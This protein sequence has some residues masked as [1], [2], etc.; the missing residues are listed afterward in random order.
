M[1]NLTFLFT[2]SADEYM[3]FPPGFYFKQIVAKSSKTLFVS[4]SGK[5]FRQLLQ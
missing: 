5:Y 1:A 4:P 2:A 3:I